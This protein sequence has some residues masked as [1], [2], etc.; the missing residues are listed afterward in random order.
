MPEN[1][2]GGSSSNARLFPGPLCPTLL[3]DPDRQTDQG[4]T[5][6]S[7]AGLCSVPWEAAAADLTEFSASG[8][9]GVTGVHSDW[10]RLP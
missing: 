8:S 4:Q 1:Q 7:P 10:P 2:A 3:L 9:G 5:Q 6:Q